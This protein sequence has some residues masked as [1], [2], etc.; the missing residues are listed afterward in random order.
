MNES[1]AKVKIFPRKENI[2]K[3]DADPEVK[4]KD[5][6]VAFWSFMI[7]SLLCSISLGYMVVHFLG[8][9]NTDIQLIYDYPLNTWIRMNSNGIWIYVLAPIVFALVLW[10]N[11]KKVMTANS[12]LVL[13]LVW[14]GILMDIMLFLGVYQIIRLNI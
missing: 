10:I 5:R 2:Q 7:F 3:I 11:L 6:Q 1:F 9:S 14:V 13:A 12:K 4:P 8:F